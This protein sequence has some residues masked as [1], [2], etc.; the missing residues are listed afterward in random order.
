MWFQVMVACDTEITII[1][2]CIRLKEG[3]KGC[4]KNVAVYFFGK[5]LKLSETIVTIK[6]DTDF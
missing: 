5:Y 4:W 2:N 1:I 3:R 6:L